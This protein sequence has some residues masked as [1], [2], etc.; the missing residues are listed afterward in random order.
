[1][2]NVGRRALGESM[3]GDD[4]HTHASSTKIV[5]MLA[6]NRAAPLGNR[7]QPVA[8]NC[9]PR[10]HSASLAFVASTRFP[11]VGLCGE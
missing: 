3:M 10:D 9:P 4:Y 7:G 2:M 8:C 11:R 6:R 1:M 5:F